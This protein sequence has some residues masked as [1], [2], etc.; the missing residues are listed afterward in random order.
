[1]LKPFILSHDISCFMSRFYYVLIFNYLIFSNRSVQNY[2]NMIISV[3]LVFYFTSSSTTQNSNPSQISPLSYNKS[4]FSL[5][6]ILLLHKTF[7]AS[8]RFVHTHLILRFV[9]SSEPYHYFMI[10]F[11][12]STISNILVFFFILL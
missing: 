5:I 11:K 1:M 2:H 8:F 10:L 3:I 4:T 9:S 7:S 6:K 12:Y